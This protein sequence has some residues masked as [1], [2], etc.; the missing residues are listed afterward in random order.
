MR[1]LTKGIQDD[2]ALLVLP[3]LF[4]T[5]YAFQSIKET[6]MMAEDISGETI[7]FLQDLCRSIGCVICAG[8]A[9]IDRDRDE[10]YNSAVLVDENE[11]LGVY[12]KLH[13][14]NKETLFFSPGNLPLAVHTIGGMKVGMMICFDWIYPEVARTLAL[15]DADIIAHPANL[16]LPY[17]Q[18]AMITRCLENHVFAITANRVGRE[19]RGMDNFT[20]TGQSQVTSFD[21]T[22]LAKAPVGVPAVKIVEINQKDARNK[23]INE[24]NDLIAGR[25]P[26]MY[27]TR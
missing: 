6:K 21:G 4:A 27:R 18:D 19:T 13:L 9:E 7:H 16:V 23:K 8:F 26:S 1:E 24:F 22:V 25:R 14:F 17:C 15:L 2:V 10:L 11:V 3:E 20:F 5:G 12:R